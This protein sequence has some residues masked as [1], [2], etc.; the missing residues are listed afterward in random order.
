MNFIKLSLCVMVCVTCLCSLERRMWAAAT[1]VSQARGDPYLRQ[2]RE[3]EE[4]RERED[5][6]GLA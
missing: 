5:G 3:T 2:K 4:L 6:H 1:P